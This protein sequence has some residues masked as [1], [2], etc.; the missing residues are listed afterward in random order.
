MATATEHEK[1]ASFQWR[2]WPETEALI[3]E[4]TQQALS[5]NAFAQA[6]AER[7]MPE[8]GTIF[9]NWLDHFVVAGP[10][11][12]A[13]RLT[14][15]GYE[16]T[17]DTHGVGVPVYAHPGGVFP[18]IAVGPRPGGGEA[19]VK[20]VGIKVESVAAF[21]GAHDLGLKIQGYPMGPLRTARVPGEGTDLVVVER[22]AYLGFENFPSDAAREGRMKPHAAREAL[23]ARD[24]WVARRRRF[25]DDAEGFA[26]TEALVDKVIETAGSRDLACHLIFEVERDYWQ[27]RNRAA[28]VQKARQDKLGLGWAN[29]DH[30]TF[31]SS[32]RFFPNLIRIFT[33]LGFFLRESFHA[34]EHAGWGAQVLEHPTTG[35]V[36]FADLDL[37]PEEATQDFSHMSLPDLARPGTV[38]LWVALHGESILDSGM[39][40]LEAQFEFDALR[41]GLKAQAGIETMKPFSDFPFLRQAF[42]AGER[43]AVSAR[44]AGRALAEGWITHE[45]HDK[46]LREGTIGSHLENLQRREGYKGFNQ[47]AVSA[48]IAATDPRLH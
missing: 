36:I 30:H 3:D 39:H 43:W 23:A 29:H 24:L 32:R 31:R 27:S 37:A 41:D 5:R 6:L 17:A 1:T 47:Q 35:I 9:Q 40:H 12:F 46:F 28:Q 38:G 15:L 14:T 16:R 18:R 26:V 22:R 20:D 21:S 13:N 44:R 34:G 45:Q 10:P 25:E 2:R 42:T 8:T 11:S 7:L 33:K 19:V 4:L 48:I